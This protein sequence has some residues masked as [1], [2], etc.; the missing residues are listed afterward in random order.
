MSTRAKFISW[1]KAAIWIWPAE[2][3]DNHFRL[4]PGNFRYFIPSFLQPINQAGTTLNWIEI[5]F[6]NEKKGQVLNAVETI[7]SSVDGAG[8]S[9]EERPNNRT[10]VS[11]HRI[12]KARR[13]DAGR[14]VCEV[15]LCVLL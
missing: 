10:I 8:Q 15:R 9:G 1:K 14:Y 2:L 6:K 7:S 3:K 4:S 13:V 12:A 5:Y 11:V